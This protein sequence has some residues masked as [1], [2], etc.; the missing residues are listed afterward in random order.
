MRELAYIA[1]AD[2]GEVMTW[3]PDGVTIKDSST[4]TREQ[5]AIVAEANEA[6][7]KY[8]AHIGLKLHSKNEALGKLLDFLTPDKRIA[9]NTVNNVVVS[10]GDVDP[11]TVRLLS[12]VAKRLES[13]PSGNG[14]Q[15]V[16]GKL[17]AG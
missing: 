3:G 13:G 17:E 2:P 10:I 7:T 9:G 5:R 1:F 15:V 8:S 11:E 16:E 12:M 4:L 6:R 14:G